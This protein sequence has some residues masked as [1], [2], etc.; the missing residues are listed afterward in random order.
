MRLNPSWVPQGTST[1]SGRPPV[2]RLIAYSHGVWSVVEVN[3][4]SLSDYDH[5]LWV[6]AGM[7][8][9][10][11]WPDRPYKIVAIHVAG[12]RPRWAPATWT[13]S[14][15]EMGVRAGRSHHTW[16]VY[17]VS[18][19][20]PMCSCCREPVPCRAE[21][22]DREVSA[23]LDEV[24]VFTSRAPGSCWGCGKKIT[25]RA[26]QVAYPGDNLDLPGG[27][28]VRFHTRASCHLK[29]V[30][31]EQRWLNSDPRRERVLTWPECEGRLLVH[32]DGTSECRNGA[33]LFGTW[34][35][36]DPDCQ[37]HLT[38]DHKNASTCHTLHGGCP[39]GCSTDPTHYISSATP[40]PPRR[41]STI[42][43]EDNT[44]H[45]HPS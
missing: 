40:R 37:G 12:A 32:A 2:G 38:H 10:D 6:K 1:V 44:T 15:V 30:R 45:D 3:D 18:G 22:E 25:A 8:A 17:P 28:P 11:T 36:N 20:W 27:I 34:R 5:E 19:R 29:A 14:R 23:A 9:L 41:P 43:P 7:P 21:L 31:Y 4:V 35:E 33:D 39:R 42:P 13:G 16:D 24:A 26:S